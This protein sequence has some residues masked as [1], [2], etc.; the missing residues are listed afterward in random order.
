ME[1]Q[2]LWGS[3]FVKR[4]LYMEMNVQTEGT[5]SCGSASGAE[6]SRAGSTSTTVS[7]DPGREQVP[8]ASRRGSTV[9]R[10]TLNRCAFGRRSSTRG[11]SFR[12]A[13]GRLKRR[14]P[15][16]TALVCHVEQRRN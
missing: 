12:D 7:R 11:P 10:A 3:E 6:Q 4:T 13:V 2:Q 8:A 9:Q 15:E 5:V 1:T 14:Q 16:S